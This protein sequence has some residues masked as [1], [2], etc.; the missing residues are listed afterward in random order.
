MKKNN[1]KEGVVGSFSGDPYSDVLETV[2]KYWFKGKNGDLKQMIESG[3]NEKLNMKKGYFRTRV[4]HV[5]NGH[6]GNAELLMAM[7]EQIKPR[8][9]AM[10][11]A[12]MDTSEM[13]AQ[14]V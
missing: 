9:E 8:K 1:N 3:V 11:K 12:R 10:E 5:L 6:V 14:R 7:Y 13:M 2:K 4:S